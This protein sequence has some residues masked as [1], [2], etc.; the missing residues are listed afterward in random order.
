[1]LAELTQNTFVTGMIKVLD[2]AVH[3]SD[4]KESVN[5]HFDFEQYIAGLEDEVNTD[6]TDG[7]SAQFAAGVLYAAS[8]QTIDERD[9]IVSCSV[10]DER[11]NRRLGNAFIDYNAGN[12]RGGNRKMRKIDNNYRNSMANCTETNDYFE[13]IDA[14]TDA[15]LNQKAWRDEARANYDANKDYVD[16][17]WQFCLDSWNQGIYFNAGMFYTRVAMALQDVALTQF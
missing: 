14:Q 3:K 9:Y 13:R 7:D 4:I 16:Q 12:L 2:T 5:T 10:H 17:Q 6:L 11:L 15:F 8:N 1:M